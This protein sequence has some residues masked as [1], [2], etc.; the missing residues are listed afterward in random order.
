MDRSLDLLDR[1]TQTGDSE[2]EISRLI[3]LKSS[4]LGVARH[5]GHLSPVAAGALA[6]HLGLDPALW[7]A[8]AAFETA[9]Q[10]SKTRS[11]LA[12]LRERARNS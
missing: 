12:R 9:P 3:G 6:A 10:T 4:T 5:R 2:R 8:I 7:T 11:L 1:A